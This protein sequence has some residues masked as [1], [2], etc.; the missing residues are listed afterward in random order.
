MRSKQLRDDIGVRTSKRTSHR[1]TIA[2]SEVAVVVRRSWG[3]QIPWL[4]TV[5]TQSTGADHRFVL[6][7]GLIV[8]IRVILRA[9]GASS[10]VIIVI[11]QLPS[12]RR[13]CCNHNVRVG[14]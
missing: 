13:E 6:G 5:A 10:A 14:T 7:F 8:R 1:A 12:R 11:Q 4:K 9:A 3:E 2:I